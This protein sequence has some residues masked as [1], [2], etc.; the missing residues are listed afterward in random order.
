MFLKNI[1]VG[2]EMVMLQLIELK[3]EFERNRKKMT[4]SLNM[5]ECPLKIFVIS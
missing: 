5:F 2:V 1:L 4:L 3:N